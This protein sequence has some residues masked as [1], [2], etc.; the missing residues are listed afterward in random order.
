MNE[1][2]QNNQK[3][4]AMPS[5]VSQS[6]SV[7]DNVNER[8]RS[9]RLNGRDNPNAAQVL[10]DM[11]EQ[12]SGMEKSKNAGIASD[13]LPSSI[14]EDEAYNVD[15][16]LSK[17]DSAAWNTAFSGQQ[18]VGQEEY[19]MGGAEAKKRDSLGTQ[20]AAGPGTKNLQSRET[21]RE[22]ISVGHDISS[23]A[24]QDTRNHVKQ[25][26]QIE[27]SKENG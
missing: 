11:N 19:S 27:N 12:T 10:K 4:Q 6:G 24:K 20:V 8:N 13:I 23:L 18:N 26:T 3:R 5:T 2:S 15:E 21:S 14:A 25:P 9:A 16:M 1:Q 22:N 7:L 17:M